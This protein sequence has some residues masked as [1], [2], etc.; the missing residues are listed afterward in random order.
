MKITHPRPEAG[1]QEFLGIEFR[2]GV[3]IVD[4]VH[5]ER[6]LALTQHGA[7][8]EIEGMKLEDLTVRELREIADQEGIDLPSKATKA[9]I[10]EALENAPHIPV[11]DDPLED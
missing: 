7:T 10:I 2:D 5:P 6:L 1:R 11:L 3:A 9:R 8:V 4:N